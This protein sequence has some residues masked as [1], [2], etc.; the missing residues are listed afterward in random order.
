MRIDLPDILAVIPRDRLAAGVDAWGKNRLRPKAAPAGAQFQ[1]PA[2]IRRSP[3][4]RRMFLARGKAMAD[5][6]KVRRRTRGMPKAARA[7]KEIVGGRDRLCAIEINIGDAAMPE[8]NADIAGAPKVGRGV[9]RT[10]GQALPLLND[11]PFLAVRNGNDPEALGRLQDRRRWPAFFARQRTDRQAASAFAP[12][13]VI[14][15]C[16]PPPSESLTRR[17]PG[18]AAR[19]SISVRGMLVSH[20]LVSTLYQQIYQ[21]SRRI[22]TH[23]QKRPWTEIK[24]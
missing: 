2:P 3:L 1:K 20:L 5:V 7:G 16:R 19:I 21:L 17:A 10:D 14:H 13:G 12:S 11:R 4:A 18:F 24:H 22:P 15:N 9:F 8:D 6:N 23:I